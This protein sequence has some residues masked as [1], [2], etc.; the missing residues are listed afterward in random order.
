MIPVIVMSLP[1]MAAA[2]VLL[3]L[4]H[5]VREWPARAVLLAML[6]AGIA[7]LA[8]SVFAGGRT[9]APE[10]PEH[11]GHAM[12]PTAVG[13]RSVTLS[14]YARE[15]AEIAVAPAR[16]QFVDVEVRMVGKVRYDERRLA[17]V[18]AWIGGR[19]DR[20]FVAFTGDTVE[21]DKE[22]VWIYSPPLRTAQEE[23]IQAVRTVE[24]LSESGLPIVKETADRTVKSARDRLRL[25]GL[26]ARQIDEIA[27]SKVPTDHISIHA[28][29]TGTVIERNGWVGMWVDQGTR[30]YTIADLSVV[31]VMLDAY[32]SD[33]PWIRYG[34]EA[35][36]VPKTSPGEKCEGKVAFI[37]PFLN[38]R[39]RTANVR[40]NAD[41]PKGRL[42]PDVFVNGIVRSRVAAGGK[43]VDPRLAGKWMCPRD[44]EVMADDSG[45]CPGCGIELVKTA[46]FGFV[47]PQEAEPPL[48]V[49]VS[50]PLIT[51][52]R[53]LVYVQ[54]K[55][56][57][58]EGRE[59]VLGPRA[60]EFYIVEHGLDEGELV[61]V[62]GNFT[63]DSAL[64]LMGKPSMMNPKGGA[65]PMRHGH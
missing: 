39:T 41:N 21:K 26:T 59:V 58:Y 29:I 37:D 15:L 38:D 14:P 63:I 60:G 54:L 4:L 62:R 57:E 20:L 7:G 35:E 43:I 52:K 27:R 22:M 50:A 48:V 17:Y 8:Y 25:W 18:T 5:G 47:A 65:A 19:I 55:E 34:Q 2:I 13:P 51:G 44:P 28:P 61:V 33:L 23:L 46:E 45:T 32:E 49:P 9:P 12:A 40:L 10:P 53:A 30:I 64:Q 16:R 11:A 31:W 6:A 56:G 36:A 1:L 42:K 3:R 24:R